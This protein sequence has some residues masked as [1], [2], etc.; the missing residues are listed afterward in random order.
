MMSTA[1]DTRTKLEPPTE[2]E[3]ES[4]KAVFKDLGWYEDYWEPFFQDNLDFKEEVK[5]QK[6]NTFPIIIKPSKYCN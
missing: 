2:L 3:S 4:L 5:N 1:Y 6:N